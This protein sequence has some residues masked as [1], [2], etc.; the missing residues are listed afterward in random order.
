M[1]K[2]SNHNFALATFIKDIPIVLAIVT[3]TLSILVIGLR[4]LVNPLRRF[5]GDNR[6]HPLLKEPLF[7]TIFLIQ[8]CYLVM[9]LIDITFTT[10]IET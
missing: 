5:Q 4:K 7:L 1:S 8:V 3:T 2:T 6:V 10:K 9:C